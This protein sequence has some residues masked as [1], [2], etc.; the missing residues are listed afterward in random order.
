MSGQKECARDSECDEG[1]G[2][3]FDSNTNT[4]ASTASFDENLMHIDEEGSDVPSDLS[5]H[6][7]EH[8][9]ESQSKYVEE[10]IN[11]ML[12][13]FSD[14][15]HDLDQGI[16]I[17]SD[18]E[19]D[20]GKDENELGEDM[21]ELK[22][23][24]NFDSD[25]DDEEIQEDNG[26]QTTGNASGFE[27]DCLN[28]SE[29]R[30]R[31]SQSDMESIPDLV[32]SSSS[33]EASSE[34]DSNADGNTD[35]QAGVNANV[36]SDDD[37]IPPLGTD[38]SD[39]DLDFKDAYENENENETGFDEEYPPLSSLKVKQLEGNSF[40]VTDLNNA[41]TV[42]DI[43]KRI[44]EQVF[45]ENEWKVEE[46]R[47]IYRGKVLQ[48]KQRVRECKLEDDSWIHLVKQARRT[49]QD[50]NE[51]SNTGD[52]SGVD[53]SIEDLDMGPLFGE[54]P[55]SMMGDSVSRFIAAALRQGVSGGNANAD[56]I[57]QSMAA[58]T[59]SV[60][61]AASVRPS[62]EN[63]TNTNTSNNLV[64][65]RQPPLPSEGNLEHIYQGLATIETVLGSLEDPNDAKSEYSS[66]DVESL[67]EDLDDDE[68]CERDLT[69]SDEGGNR[70]GDAEEKENTHHDN[71]T[72][73][74][75]KFI[76]GQWVDVLDTVN[77]WL[78]A[79]IM[80]VS[81][82][83]RR[84]HIHYNAWGE[85]WDEVLDAN[86]NRIAPFRTKT[87]QGNGCRNLSATPVSWV[88]SA[89]TVAGESNG[90]NLNE[91]LPEAYRVLDNSILPLL[92][93]VCESTNSE[94][95]LE[96]RTRKILHLA[97]V[98][99]RM[100][101][102]LSDLA[103]RLADRPR[104]LRRKRVLKLPSQSTLLNLIGQSVL[105]LGLHLPVETLN[106]GRNPNIMREERNEL[107]SRYG[108]DPSFLE[109]MQDSDGLGGRNRN[110]DIHIHAIVTP[111]RLN[112]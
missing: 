83:G 30:E 112:S 10:I 102:L 24:S 109:L 32:T 35:I 41:M 65:Q 105:P 87:K 4:N 38:S 75:R 55:G 103:P 84:V 74:V 100:G 39:E 53:M 18:E 21:P 92:K 42:L 93:E 89:P 77:Q 43:K 73:P 51:T 3:K 7:D 67:L 2:D 5:S 57:F 29:K 96:A 20:K 91:V 98:L 28:G 26:Q 76:T 50:V 36:D 8:E 48:D 27:R 111:T 78:E 9:E 33:S 97:P 14:L 80:N 34:L 62:P 107:V 88:Q 86:S 61:A 99:D 72:E 45:K 49:E 16:N 58:Q 11:D 104:L 13:S 19:E 22:S 95:D 1:K 54:G 66:A 44:H 101:R 52:R 40:T 23:V 69:A 31:E 94:K 110:L 70:F 82:D 46:Q 81:S 56:T 12:D 64:R 108:Y 37:S 85:R 17:G 15:L 25:S 71:S 60:G 63:G 68:L 6:D 47:I 79:T 90:S 106:P 59:G